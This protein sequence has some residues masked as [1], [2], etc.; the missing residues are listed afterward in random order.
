MEKKRV[1]L[2]EILH[3]AL[4]ESLAKAKKSEKREPV[5]VVDKVFI[6]WLD[7][8][9][10]AHD[11]AHA[12]HEQKQAEIDAELRKACK[13]HNEQNK[14]AWEAILADLGV[15]KEQWNTVEFHID[16]ESGL[17]TRAMEEPKGPV[18]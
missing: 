17:V 4:G 15:P 5:G 9:T 10:K 8:S 11:E 18:Q 14:E 7:R 1:S 13:L 2:L 12:L 3:E 16:A 6:D